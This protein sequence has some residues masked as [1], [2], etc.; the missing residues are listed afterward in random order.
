MIYPY[1]LFLDD[2]RDP[3]SYTTDNWIA[4]R[5]Y[6]EAIAIIELYGMPANISFDHDLGDCVPTGHDFAKK[7]VEMCLDGIVKFPDDISFGIQSI[8]P[9]R[10]MQTHTICRM[11]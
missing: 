6:D 5:S 4:A 10:L 1:S 8:V 11:L 9:I 2:L 3:P 7:L